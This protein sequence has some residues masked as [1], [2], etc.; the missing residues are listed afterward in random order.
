[1]N[2][3]IFVII[4]ISSFIFLMQ[5]N[6]NLRKAAT[7]TFFQSGAAWVDKLTKFLIKNI[8]IIKKVNC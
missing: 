2:I 1:M 5:F 8:I 6:I 7:G 3:V 4:I